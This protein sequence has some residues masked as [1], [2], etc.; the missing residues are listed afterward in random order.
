MIFALIKNNK[1]DNIIAADQIF[2][3]SLLSDYQAVVQSDT[4]Q[5]GWEWDGTSIVTPPAPEP[6]IMPMPEPSRLV[7]R[8][9]F[10][11]RFTLAEKMALELAGLDN[12]ASTIAE[13]TN[14]AA[15]RIN[16]ADLAAA[17]FVDLA[18]E[19]TR[20]GVL[21]LETVGLLDAGRALEILDTPVTE[22]EKFVG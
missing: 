2:A 9:A 13:R 11:N 3:D 6:V 21:S 18:R 10:R 20:N 17:T 12:P 14:A 16:Q 5:V 8:L 7:T 15:L 19:D 4:A 1:V 22:L